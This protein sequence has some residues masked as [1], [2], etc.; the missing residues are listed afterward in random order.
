MNKKL[1]LAFAL[2]GLSIASA[3]TYSISFSDRF[4]VGNTQLKPGDYR[5]QVEGSKAI[6]KDRENRTA[7]EVNV[8]VQNS[9]KKFEHTEIQS[10]QVDGNRRIEEIR[11]GG[12]RTAL[13]FD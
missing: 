10:K 5:L 3:K 11:L 2:A 6:F 12:T 7:A 9:Q 13:D 4:M 1:L 8:K